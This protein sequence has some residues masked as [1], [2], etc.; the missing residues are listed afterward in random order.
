[1][2]AVVRKLLRPVDPDQPE[3]VEIS[4][5][6]ADHLYR[7]IRLENTLTDLDGQQ[8]ALKDGARLDITLEAAAA[9]TVKLGKTPAA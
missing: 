6:A 7:E 9:D 8:V 4:I 1:V 5:A 3:K 2:P